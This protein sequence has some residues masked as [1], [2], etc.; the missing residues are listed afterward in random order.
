MLASFI[1][2]YCSHICGRDN[3]AQRWRLASAWANSTSGSS[4]QN[5]TSL[6]DTKARVASVGRSEVANM[7][8]CLVAAWHGLVN[9]PKKSWCY[10]LWRMQMRQVCCWIELFHSLS[11]AMWRTS[12]VKQRRHSKPSLKGTALAQKMFTRNFIIILNIWNHAIL[13]Y[14]LQCFTEG[15][16]IIK[17]YVLSESF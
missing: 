11:Q 17:F 12:H 10:Q 1:R 5:Y 16:I 8:D 13:S 15:Y 2:I 9:P 7:R 3:N 6:T 4:S 14:I